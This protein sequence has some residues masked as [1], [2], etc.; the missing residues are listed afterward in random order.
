MHIA[1]S[2]RAGAKEVGAKDVSARSPLDA[3][4]QKDD[5]VRRHIGPSDAEIAHMLETLGLTSLDDLVERAV[6]KSIRSQAP[7]DL[8]KILSS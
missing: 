7:L 8:S 2:E 3:L 4:E 6:P 5:F 1:K